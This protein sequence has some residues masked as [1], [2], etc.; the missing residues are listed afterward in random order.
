MKHLDTTF[1]IVWLCLFLVILIFGYF[2]FMFSTS[3]KTIVCID[4]NHKK[5]IRENGIT[6]LDNMFNKEDISHLKFLANSNK[7]SDIKTFVEQSRT[8]TTAIK[9]ILGSD[10]ILYEFIF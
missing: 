7:L 9:A 6:R 4:G 1:I 8:L 3:N 2:F 10:Y 5:C